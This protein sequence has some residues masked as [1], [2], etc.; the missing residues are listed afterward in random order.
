M[1]KI[2]YLLILILLFIF[3]FFCVNNPFSIARL[4]ALW[5][6]FISGSSFEKYKKDNA[7]IEEVFVL[8]E[9][10]NHYVEKFSNQIQIIRL[11]GFTAIFVA[12]IGACIILLSGSSN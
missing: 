5:F 6:R 1:E 4:I 11:S 10:Q 9:H 8:I 7:Q 3:G 2:I 12:M